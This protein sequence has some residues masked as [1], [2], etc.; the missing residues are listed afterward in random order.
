MMKVIIFRTLDP[1]SL[2]FEII[3]STFNFVILITVEN[4]RQIKTT[5]DDTSI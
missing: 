5:P 2:F 1:I 4:D 3:T